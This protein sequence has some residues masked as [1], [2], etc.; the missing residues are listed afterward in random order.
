MIKFTKEQNYYYRKELRLFRRLKD[1]FRE[2][3]P[4][5]YYKKRI[6]NRGQYIEF[7]C[8]AI[9]A[10][11]NKYEIVVND[12]NDKGEIDFKNFEIIQYAKMF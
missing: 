10:N 11:G 8:E 4:L 1:N 6:N 9:D 3:I 12:Q 2:Y 5:E 7:Y